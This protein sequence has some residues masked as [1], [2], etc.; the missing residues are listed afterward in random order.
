VQAAD[1]VIK[2]ARK[3]RTR[4]Q[5]HTDVSLLDEAEA[6][7]LATKEEQAEAEPNRMEPM[8]VL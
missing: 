7:F 1:F 2:E 4:A 3:L 5:N 8:D 6:L